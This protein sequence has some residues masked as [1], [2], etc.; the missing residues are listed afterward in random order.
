MIPAIDAVAALIDLFFDPRGL[1]R[2]GLF[3][4]AKARQE[5]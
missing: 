2:M 3:R 5:S 4:R 1:E